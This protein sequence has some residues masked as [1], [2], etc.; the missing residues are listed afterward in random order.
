MHGVV[1]LGTFIASAK[2][3]GVTRAE[4]DAIIDLVSKNPQAGEI[5]IGTGGARKVRFAR[6]G[7]GKSGGYRVITFYAAEDI[8]V[9]L[10][11]IY[12]KGDKANLTK[13]ERN[14]LAK[15]LAQIESAYRAGTRGRADAIKARGRSR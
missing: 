1:E 4:V 6:S 3:A 14:D 5:M 2:K 11:D 9:M 15:V 7:A 10:L 8:P 13:A 12:G